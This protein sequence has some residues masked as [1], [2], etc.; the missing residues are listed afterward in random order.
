MS[1]T[2][3]RPHNKRKLEFDPFGEQTSGNLKSHALHAHGEYFFVWS[4]GLC[5]LWNID[6]M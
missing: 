5:S 2:C 6:H 4:H 1:T 3:F